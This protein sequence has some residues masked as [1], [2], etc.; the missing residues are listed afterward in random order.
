MHAA[1]Y[2]VV[3][4]GSAGCA[5]AYRLSEDERNTVILL[6]MGGSDGGPFIRMPAALSY[7]MSMKRYDWGFRCEPEPGL[8]G[9]R[10]A[11]PRGK[12]L[13]GSSSINGMVYV[14]GHPQDF[15]EW[16]RMGASG[17]GWH[18]VEPYFRRMEDAPHGDPEKRGHGGPLRITK[19]DHTHPLAT[20]FLK[21]GEQAGY[22][23]AEDYNTADQEGM[24][25]FEKTVYGG[26]RW[27]AARAYLEPARPRLN[28]RI[29]TRAHVSRVLFEGRKAVGVE[30]TRRGRRETITALKGVVL[31]AS[32]I[33][34]PAILLRSGIGPAD[35]LSRI[36]V[37]VLVD[38]PGVGR[39]L[40]DHLEVLIQQG[41]TRPIT[42]NGSMRLHI[43]AALGL[44]WLVTRG[45]VG[46]SNHFEAGAFLRSRAD[47]AY[48]DVQMHF[49]AGAIRYD[50]R[51]AA[52][53][54][55]QI[56]V[57]PMRSKARGHVRLSGIDPE[58]PPLIGFN[59]MQGE[60]D[61]EDF[62]RAVAMSRSIFAQP[63]FAPYR[64]PELLP[65]E[66][67]QSDD[68]IDAF[69]REHVESAYH[70]CGTCRMGAADDPR[71]VVD[72]RCR[73]IGTEGLWVADSSIFPRITNGNTNAP[74]IMVGEKASD[75]ILGRSALSQSIPQREREAA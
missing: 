61:A 12:V 37:P 56:H 36:G 30:T 34:S 4:A 26:E 47:V 50:G 28:L 44:R 5:L 23:L 59:Y 8:D 53:H 74:S 9:R 18:G 58:A 29:I 35:E 66:D 68:D 21:A 64:G 62:R 60:G 3:G 48:P 46:A 22:P 2:I 32:S 75:H 45:G 39:N 51:P 40:Q 11:C 14:R 54:G 20:A 17:W 24:T 38:R 69:I 7:P 10:L 49:L 65:G 70:P 31:A 43:K 73:V 67:V 63:A 72:P 15:D 57:G 19:G 16:E 41:C 25:P 13:G 71:A 55:F 52:M 42:L 33:N 27:S 1:D 6:E